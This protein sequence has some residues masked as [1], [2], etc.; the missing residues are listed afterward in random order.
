MRS[1]AFVVALVACLQAAAWAV[2]DKSASAP[3]INGP[4]MSVSYSPF[5]GEKIAGD[6][7]LRP[8]P[9]QI[10]S[11]LRIIAPYT[12]AVRTYRATN[13]M[14]AV[15]GIAKELGLKVSLGAW[16]DERSFL[17]P[18]LDD[19][20]EPRTEKDRQILAAKATT[21]S[22]IKAVIKQAKENPNINA[23]F[24]GNE[25]LLRAEKE[26][27]SLG[28]AVDKLV[29]LIQRVK[30]ETGGTI[31]VTTGETWDV[32]LDESPAMNRLVSEIDF[33]SVHV[34]PYWGG[35]PANQAAD[36]A[37]T[38]YNKM[39]A[40]YPGKRIVIAEFGWPST[41]YNRGPADPGQMEQAQVTRE[42]IA[43]AEA[44][45]ID[46][47]LIEAFDQ[48]WKTAEGSV[49][50]YWGLFNTDRAP[51]FAWS[52]PI[53]DPN[54]WKLAAIA[55]AIGVLLSLPILTIAGVTV[56]QAAL[57]ALAANAVGGWLATAFQFWNDHYFVAGS[58]F[59]FG[60]GMALLIPLLLIGLSRIED[61]AAIVFGPAPRRLLAA[62]GDG[63][64]TPK[65]SI[66]IPAHME[67]PEMLK[68]TLD[69]VARLNYP[70]FECV[71]VINNT[72]DPAYWS[73]VE[74]HCRTLGERFIFIN[75]QRI[76]GYKAGALRLALEHTAPDAEIIGVIDADYVVHPDWLKDVVPAFADPK[77]GLIQAP[78]DHRDG[79][80][81]PM[82]LAMNGEYAGFFD[83]G[84]VQRNEDNAIIVHGTMCLIRR[85][86]LASAGGW[87]SDTICEDT[88]LGL[89]ILEQGWLIHYTNRRYGHGLLPESFEA[90]KKQRYRWAY[91]GLQIVKKH[92]QRFLPTSSRLSA[93]Q[94][95][96]FAIGWLNWLGA[97]SIGVL[98]AILNL[99][100]VP[101]VAFVGI[102][103]PDKVLTLPIVI[104][105]VVSMAH[106]AAL[107]RRRVQITPGQMMMA[108]V[109]AMSMQW[110]VAR[111]VGTG[112][113]KDH[114]PFV[115]TAKGGVSRTRVSF[116]AFYESIMGG[117][118][119]L[120]AIA[121]IWT[122]YEHVR[123]INLFACVLLVQS[124]PFAAAVAIAALEGSPLN[125]FAY[126][127]A[128]EA[129][130]APWL[131]RRRTLALPAA[132]VSTGEKRAEPAQ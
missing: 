59:A 100:W 43:N 120:G 17:E 30:R 122:N 52:G 114:L 128:V 44:L 113:V 90:F 35:V 8:T 22:E 18:K 94:R 27:Q 77:V 86:A 121:V 42:F 20:G 127:Q 15:P 125:D 40:Q 73:A 69:A 74:E 98:M 78:Q 61:I 103:I 131:P 71:V 41:G 64:A 38:I 67:P 70:N 118:L 58:A 34:L 79:A 28:G 53:S 106:F 16:V 110:T 39:R 29:A 32:W 5:E 108:M 126:W 49:G 57:L 97:E 55:I 60:L 124:L 37:V 112:L 84:M 65:V 36:N 21:E 99:I 9:A 105:F 66:H 96:T 19:K 75:A 12:R 101:I 91:G 2:F 95:R 46:Y 11:H 23:I 92:W 132:D 4:L 48:P 54:H 50:A 72:P 115:R 1:A 104:A 14:E 88:D 47:N 45:G 93:E 129:R 83:I 25:T 68:A 107:Y 85:T 7:G 10:R 109:A 89:S 102:A 26:T 62:G 80:K 56:P 13:G 76:E 24:V 6:Q 119:V 130:L 33:I 82:H 117:L 81:S 123:E 3:A 116:P 87:S 31:P 111:A 51:K 63:G